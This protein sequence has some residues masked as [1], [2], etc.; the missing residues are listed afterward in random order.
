MSRISYVN[1]AFVPHTE[2]V[3]H[4]EDRGYQFADGIYEVMAVHHGVM[5][6]EEPHYNRLIRSLKG[7]QITLPLPIISFKMIIHELLRRNRCK[8][9]S[10]YIQVSRG[11]AKRNHEFPKGVRPS[12]VVVIN[13]GPARASMNA[14]GVGT[15]ISCPDIRWARRDIKSISL[16]PNILA[17]QKAVEA[18]CTE[19]FLVDEKGIISEGSATNA[20]MVDA[21]GTI[22][23][24]PADERILGG[25]TRD[26]VLKVARQGKMKVL[27]RPFTLKEALAAKELFI[28]ST[29]KGVMPIVNLDKTTIGTGKCGEVTSQLRLLYDVYVTERLEAIA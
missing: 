19:A 17:K 9:G 24:H 14:S 4:I 16:L 6:D 26:S 7:L 1:G 21:K 20:Y 29:T 12:L 3:V 18:G 8:N 11:V 10:I 27:E 28:T 15:A 2:A 5:I 13:P 22:I 25:I 23:T